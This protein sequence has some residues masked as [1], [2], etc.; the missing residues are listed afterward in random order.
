MNPSIMSHVLITGA[1]SG[2][3]YELAR[4]F[5]E[6]G[7]N[8]ILVARLEERLAEVQAELSGEFGVDVRVLDVD[9]FDPG[10]AAEIHRRVGEAGLIVDILVNNA[11]QGEHGEFATTDLGRQLAI[12]QLNVGAVVALTHYFLQDMLA[13]K[14]G[15][16]L[17]LG[18]SYSK[19]P[20]PFLS[21]YAA[22]KAFVLSFGEALANECIDSG[23]TVTV[24]MPGATDTDFFHK[25]G[26]ERSKVY[27]ESN[28]A[29]PAVVARDGH[30][31]LMAGRDTVVSGLRNKVHS[32][33]ADITPHTFAAARARAVGEPTDKP[34]DEIRT[35]ATHPASRRER[36]ALDHRLEDPA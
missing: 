26:A 4:V 7:K 27:A 31:A 25:A 8:L 22:T 23:V 15:K 32:M 30:A 14:S 3:G 18:S 20:G 10:A 21:V 36:E 17:M 34:A 28:L 11:G 13:R 1:T 2:I 24:L 6:H 9:L 5:A 29:D 33:M 12:V 35:H 16:I 19:I